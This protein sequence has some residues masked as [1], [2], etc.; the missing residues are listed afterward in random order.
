MSD[1]SLITY[2]NLSKNYSTR[3]STIDSII[4]HCFVGQ[5]TAKSGCDYFASTDRQASSNYV[6]GFDGSIGLSVKETYR[7][8]TSGGTDAN[9]NPIRVNGISG[10]DFDHRAVT[11]EVASDTSSPYAVTDAAYKA[12]INLCADI[13]KRNNIKKLLWMGDKKYVGTAKQNMGAHRWFAY[14]ACP[15]DYLY[16]KMGDIANKV[17][18]ILE[19]DD[20]MDQ[21]KFNEMFLIAMNNYRQSLRDNDSSNYS[22]EARQWAIDNGLMSGNGTIASDGKP[23]MMWEDMISREQ[24]VVVDKRLYEFIMEQV[25]KL[26]A[27]G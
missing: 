25:K 5:V 27:N 10:A 17:N 21:A 20:D 6:V 18:Q 16:N 15:G 7:A 22:A 12:L 8:W 24:N 11:I 9:G 4:I 14:K 3:R 13:C 2:T 1:S 19:D 23:N 26:I